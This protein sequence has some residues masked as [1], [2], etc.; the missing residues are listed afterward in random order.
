MK[1]LFV[2]IL[3]L[4]IL[5]GGY[6]V[7][8]NYYPFLF[9]NLMPVSKRIKQYFPL[10]S[11]TISPFRIPKDY[12][13]DIFSDLKTDLPNVIIF[14]VG[15]NL[16]ASL[17]TKGKIVV[18]TDDNK[19]F[20][21]DRTTVLLSGLNRPYGIA[22]Y[23]N[24]LYVAESNGVSRYI[25]DSRNSLVGGKELLFSLPNGG[26][27]YTR[28][29]KINNDKLFTTVGSSCDSC[30][31]KDN[32]RASILVSN[33]DG[34]GLKV[35]AKGLRNTVAIDFDKD[36]NLWGADIGRDGL[37]FGLPPEEINLIQENNDYGWPYCYGNRVKD[38][39]FNQDVAKTCERTEAPIY[40]MP[41]RSRPLS[42]IFDRSGNIYL[43]LNGSK[44][45][46][47]SV[48][49]K[50]VRLRSF[51]NSI[52]TMEDYVVGFVQGQDQVM[53]GPS[54]LA[55][56]KDDNLYI[57]DNRSGMIYVLRK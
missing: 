49:Y 33:L 15:G 27:N 42:L 17:T 22:L 1:K 52:S 38:T 13:M 32:L 39:K 8:S 20:K 30:L 57:A 47:E 35:F 50:V 23:G 2:W 26:K 53:G 37:G 11:E 54:G 21:A 46:K 28:T 24:Y 12:K 4:T 48:G 19:D 6:F 14:D 43:S 29:I 18:I 51:A 31:E 5:F 45:L 36:G 10:S 34:S 55:L 3:I 40:E 44:N 41:A 16:I 9:S 25:Y 56:D 7:V